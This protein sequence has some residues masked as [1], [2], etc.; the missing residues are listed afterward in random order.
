MATYAFALGDTVYETDTPY[1]HLLVADTYDPAHQSYVRYLILD[2]NLHS[3]MDLRSPDRTVFEYTDYFQLGFLLNPAISHV[4][5]IGGGGF[6]GPKAFLK[7]YAN[8]TVDV[9][10]IDPEVIRVAEQYFGVNSGSPRLRIFND[11]GRIYL[12]K[13]SQRYDLVILDA[14]SRS[15]VP[16]H[17]MTAEFFQL[18]A[19]HLTRGGSV[20]SNLIASTGNGA[21]LLQAEVKTM[22]TAFPKIYLFPVKGA[23]YLEPQNIEILATL[24][25]TTYS[26]E[27][28][29]ELATGNP[30]VRHLPS[31]TAYVDNYYVIGDSSAPVLTD[32]FAPVENMLNPINGLPL[33]RG[34]SPGVDW[35]ELVNVVIATVGISFLLLVLIRKKIL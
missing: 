32:N 22:G 7:N 13:S 26:K 31:L 5:F 3:A 16:F 15:Y 8:L 24:I 27:Q 35:H 1:H 4:L 23:N 12:T 33:M 30:L 20:I 34:E 29:E 14:Y 18:L 28:F 19:A 11:D 6:T 2:D 25:T 17:M 9:V 10:E 21:Q